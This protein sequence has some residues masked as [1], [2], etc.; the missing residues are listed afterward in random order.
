[1][2]ISK[3][4]YNFLTKM[5][6]QSSCPLAIKEF[7]CH[8]LQSPY[9]QKHITTI[10]SIFNLIIAHFKYITIKKKICAVIKTMNTPPKLYNK[11]KYNELQSTNKYL[12]Q[13]HFY[14]TMKHISKS[15]QHLLIRILLFMVIKQ[16]KSKFSCIQGE[17]ILCMHGKLKIDECQT[18]I[19][20]F[21]NF[22]NE[23]KVLL[24]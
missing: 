13:F 21:N 3:T 6:S 5:T 8:F 11:Y 7:F 18:L 22:N 17:D 2:K 14:Y 15:I 20:H 24:A 12:I 4:F 19:K 1:M 10:L 9:Q 23:A 16:F